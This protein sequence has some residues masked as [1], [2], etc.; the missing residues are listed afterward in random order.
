MVLESF[1]FEC[2]SW[3]TILEDWSDLIRLRSFIKVTEPDAIIVAT[4]GCFD[5]LH[6]AHCMMLKEATF[7]GDYL[8]VGLNSDGSVR[9]LKGPKRPINKQADRKILLES[10]R[11]VDK[12]HIFNEDNAAK[13]LL[14][15]EPHFYVKAGDYSLD[16]MHKGEKEV[17]EKMGTTIIFTKF[18]PGFSTTGIINK[19]HE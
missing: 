12:V 5:I 19:L 9:K 14:V 18:I 4:N 2:D 3:N 10:L 6:S 11:F 16:T 8:F 7:L 15:A 1:M 13:F 17:L